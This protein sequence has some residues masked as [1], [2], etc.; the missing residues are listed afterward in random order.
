MS[1][2]AT[3]LIVIPAR[4]AAGHLAAALESVAAQDLTGIRVH[5]HVQDGGSTD[6]TLEIVREW[7]AR[8]SERPL[9]GDLAIT[10]ATATDGGMYDAITRALAHASEW[11]FAPELFF[12][13][14]ADDVL[15]PGALRNLAATFANQAVEWVIGAAVDLDEAGAVT[16]HK[17]HPRIPDADL[18]SGDFNYTGGRWLRAESTA[19]RLSA[20]RACGPFAPGLRLAGDYDLFVKLARRGPPTYVDYPVRGF[21]RH[22]GQL[23]QAAVAYQYERAR[24]RFMLSETD[25]PRIRP[26]LAARPAHEIV[27]YPD[28]TAIDP[29]QTLLYEGA[30]ATGMASIQHLADV[31]Q[32]ATT[33]LVVHVHWLDQ[34]MAQPQAAAVADARTLAQTLTMARARGH[35]IVFTV[36]DVADRTHANADVEEMLVEFLFGHASLVH[37]H[38]P[39]VAAEIRGRFRS[40]PWGRTVF[41]EQGP[42]PDPGVA[43]RGPAFALVGADG[44]ATTTIRGARW[45]VFGPGSAPSA[46]LLFHILAAG[47]PVV[48]P[49]LGRIPAYV[50]DG[51][52]GF[53]Y[54]PGDEASYRQAIDRALAARSAEAERA[55]GQQAVRA[56]ADLDWPTMLDTIM[57]RLA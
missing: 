45:A 51:V 25:S 6:G 20:A 14:N 35:R 56:V 27:F 23:S 43:L 50:F 8:I 47:T 1:R 40:F 33:P 29:Y 9:G 10:W 12:W 11:P 16:L 18:R 31:C 41:A 57:R 22:A 17:P 21:R 30:R 34:I 44:S 15:M 19:V 4:N 52:N 2:V 36:H 13:L 7:A 48:A 38:H 42:D 49:R 54:D 39:V 26:R 28:R 32:Q 46:G 5:V 24:A 53:L 3:F 37:L 55:L